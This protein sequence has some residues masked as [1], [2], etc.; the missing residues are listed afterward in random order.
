MASIASNSHVAGA[1]DFGRTRW[2]VVIAVRSGSESEAR[3]SLTDLCRRY[4]V[5][6]YTYVRRCGHPPESAA[7]LVQA[8]LSHLVQEIR[9]GDPAAD[10]GFR[11]FLQR[12][13]ERFLASDWTLLD[14]TAELPEFASPWPLEQI[15]QRLRRDQFPDLTPSQA[16]QRAFVLELLEHGL[17]RLREEAEAGGRGAMFEA[18]RPFLT[19]EPGPGEIAAVAIALPSSP[20][21]TLIAVKRLRQRYQELIDEQL[22]QTVGGPEAFDAERNAMLALLAPPRP[23]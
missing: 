15:E 5:P 6:V 23:A 1:A 13:L 9:A 12:R 10:G 7:S 21:A 22:A 17:E 3:Q 4:W 19:R 2:S 20:L 11:Q 8:F 18:V 16:F 14:T